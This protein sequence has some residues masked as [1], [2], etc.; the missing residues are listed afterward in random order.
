MKDE[1]KRGQKSSVVG[2]KIKMNRRDLCGKEA[3]FVWEEKKD[4]RK[5]EW[6]GERGKKVMENDAQYAMYTVCCD[7]R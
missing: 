2:N 3:Q 5:L 6:V 7:K 4:G 1:K